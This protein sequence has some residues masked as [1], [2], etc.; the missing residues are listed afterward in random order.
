MDTTQNGIY[1]LPKRLPKWLVPG[2]FEWDKLVE[3][4]GFKEANERRQAALKEKE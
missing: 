3:R 2:T 4:V 1:S